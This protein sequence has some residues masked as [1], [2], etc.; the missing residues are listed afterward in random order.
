LVFAVLIPLACGSFT[1]LPAQQFQW[2]LMPTLVGHARVEQAVERLVGDNAISARN[3]ERTM[4]RMLRGRDEDGRLAAALVLAAHYRRSGRIPDAAALVEQYADLRPENLDPQRLEAFLEYARCEAAGGR[5]LAAF[6]ALDY[7]KQNTTGLRAALVRIAYADVAEMAPEYSKAMEWLREALDIGNRWANPPAISETERSKP[8][9]GAELWP[10]LRNAIEQRLEALEFKAAMRKWGPGYVWDLYARKAWNPDRSP[11]RDFTDTSNIYPGKGAGRANVATEDLA[12]AVEMYD[13]LIEKHP[14]TVY[15]EAAKLYRAICLAHMGSSREAERDLR[16]FI[17]ESALGL[18]RGEAMLTLGDIELQGN[19]RP[20]QAGEWYLQALDWCR[21]AVS[22][23]SGARLY[24]VPEKAA[25]PAAAPD[26]WQKMGNGGVIKPGRIPPGA[27]VNRLTAEWYL[28][29]LQAELLFR[30]GFLDALAGDWDTALTYWRKIAEHDELLKRAQEKRYYNTL[31]RLEGAAKNG[32]FLGQAEENARIGARTKPA[33]W[34]ADFLHLR[35]R[36]EASGSLYARLFSAA[37]GRNDAT[38][39]ARAALGMMLAYDA[40]ANEKRR[41]ESRQL[42]ARVGEIGKMA[43]ERFPRAPAAPY[44]AFMIGWST[45]LGTAEG[46]DA[47]SAA[48]RRAHEKY[49]NSRHALE[50]RF[51]SIFTL[52]Q[53]DNEEEWRPILEEFRRDHPDSVHIQM[54]DI[55]ADGI[56]E[57]QRMNSSREQESAG[58]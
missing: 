10:P 56:H 29:W 42:K 50:A 31:R 17:S 19:W 13:Y 22:V 40:E 37:N 53:L 1:E 2:P 54:L 3:A 18:Y 45:H 47:A 34:W 23:R 32:Y 48:F 33:L 24:A 4:E 36:F 26:D 6:R 27:V 52:M 49:P 51:R 44:I 28:D 55:H 43:L 20:R 38:V 21:Q 11:A 15:A 9:E 5:T 14:E 30:L 12:D 8:P 46:K 39:A 7:A 16:K 41:G 58:H 25:E 35:K 57:L